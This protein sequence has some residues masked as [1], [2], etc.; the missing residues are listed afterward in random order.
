MFIFFGNL[1][2]I[3]NFLR[4]CF[5]EK[6]NVKNLNN[7]WIFKTGP[8]QWNWHRSNTFFH[9]NNDINRVCFL[10]FIHFNIDVSKLQTSQLFL[11]FIYLLCLKKIT[12]IKLITF[13]IFTVINYNGFSLFV[14]SMFIIYFKEIGTVIKY[15]DTFST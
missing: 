10:T 15:N 3:F 1:K 8:G 5:L 2:T 11:I 4:F 13:I 7:W 9:K 12:K 14:V 6:T